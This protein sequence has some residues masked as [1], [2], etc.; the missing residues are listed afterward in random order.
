[1]P[2]ETLVSPFSFFSL[3]FVL[4]STSTNF[5]SVEAHSHRH[6]STAGQLVLKHHRKLLTQTEHGVI[7]AAFVND[8][9]KGP[10]HLQFITLE[11][12]SVFLPVVLHADMV[13][14]VHTGSGTLSWTD[15]DDI[16]NV[17]IRK[18]DVYRL[19]Q[20]AVFYVQSNL[21]AERHKLRIYAIFTNTE[22]DTYEP[23]T[24]AY[25]SITDVVLG[26]DSRVLQAAFKVPEDVIE[27][28][29]RSSKAP[30][31]IHAVQ[32]EKKVLGEWQDGLLKAF[33]GSNRSGFFRSISGKNKK[34]TKT[35]NV[36]EADPDFENCNGWSVTVDKKDLHLLKHSNIGVFMV[37][38]TKGSMMAPHWNPRASEIAIVLQGQGM[39]RVVCSS[40]VNESECRNMRYRV[41]E[42]DVIA[43][44]R[45]HPMA[46]MSFNNDSFVFMGFSTST[47]RNHPQFLAGKR[48]SLGVVDREILALSFNV[49]NTTI[50]HLLKPQKESVIL[51][52]TSC[53]EEEERLMEEEIER[54]RK[55]EE[56]AKKKKEEEE[57]RKR[58][59]EEEEA[60]KKEEEEARKRREEEE[61]ARKKEEEEEAR[62]RR[63]EEEEARKEEEEE[64]R[65]R[66]E[67]EEEAR[68]KEKEE[69]ARKRREEAEEE[70]ARRK[71]EEEARRRREEEE[72]AR[73][74]REEEEEAR[75]KEEEE[76][77]RR[78]EEEEEARRKEE[79]EEARRRREEEE[80]ARREEKEAKEREEEGAERRREEEEAERRREEEARREQKEARRRE[81]ERQR[82]AREEE[83][84]RRR[85]EEEKGQGE[86]EGEPSREQEEARRQEEERQRRA[87]EEEEEEER[88]RHE[89]E[90]GQGEEEEEGEPSREQEEAER[91][92]KER[93]RKA[94]QEGI[95]KGRGRRIKKV[96]ET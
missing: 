40:N 90:E 3:L 79:E 84:E 36:F 56:E 59:E 16:R 95:G 25:S 37:N 88:R 72:E 28:I 47:K 6:A 44:P 21:E 54:E 31:I 96:W 29:M 53:A 39:V 15:D 10:Y 46:Q 55:E 18:G 14:F 61:E 69:E 33:L 91:R 82:R 74:R 94:E 93:H 92:E 19:H 65:K 32:K 62:K 5:L 66:R 86:E 64:A 9:T 30:A 23:S 57:T 1:M 11:P 76:A 89:E 43:V 87:R 75:R 7:S 81:E 50:D 22:D 58:R 4:A 60:R 27:E 2:K 17:D 38:L 35:Y 80:E 68:R 49:S 8:G 78:R 42:G 70:E 41:E 73:R 71:E 77:R 51:D 24:G 85:H 20:G 13:F 26:F 34:K 45:F 12:N 83:E 48:S 63:E 67:E 52:C